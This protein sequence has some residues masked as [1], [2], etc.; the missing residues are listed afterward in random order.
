ML[1]QGTKLPVGWIVF[2][3]YGA[4]EAT[5]LHPLSKS[6]ALKRLMP[7]FVPLRGRLEPAEIERLVQWV[8]TIPCYELRMSSLNEAVNLLGHLCR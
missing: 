8:Q 4:K 7:S 2:P 6:V 1:P 3:R 5:A